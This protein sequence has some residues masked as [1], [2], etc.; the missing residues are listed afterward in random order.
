MRLGESEELVCCCWRFIKGAGQRSIGVEIKDGSEHTTQRLRESHR[1]VLSIRINHVLCLFLDVERVGEHVE[2]EREIQVAKICK[3]LKLLIVCSVEVVI[4][5][6]A[7]VPAI[8]GVSSRGDEE[9]VP[10]FLPFF[11]SRGDE[12]PVMERVQEKRAL[13][14]AG[15]RVQITL[16]VVT[17]PECTSV[18]IVHRI[19]EVFAT[20]NVS[21][22]FADLWRFFL[23][24]RLLKSGVGC[25]NGS[26]LREY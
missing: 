7:I 13:V 24:S 15:L 12:R 25:E 16:H 10:E 17:R 20:I 11:V 23:I 2:D 14:Q 5:Q 3:V 4:E 18:V 6:I 26:G 1:V 22:K 9:Q 21:C 19:S 8:I